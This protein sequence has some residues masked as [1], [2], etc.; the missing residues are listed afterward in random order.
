MPHERIVARNH[1]RE[2]S[3]GP[4]A[5]HWMEHFCVHGPGDIQGDPVRHGKELTCFVADCYALE[6][7]G[8]MLYDSAFLSRPK[9]ADKSGVA[10]RFSLYEALGPCRFDGF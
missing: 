8:R 7:T 3:L 2:R 1:D 5:N 9:G 6:S 10:G 4:L